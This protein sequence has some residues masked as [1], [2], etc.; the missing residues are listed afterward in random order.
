[1]RRRNLFLTGTA[2]AL[3]LFG[4]S[5]QE[6]PTVPAATAPTAAP[7]Q[8][9]APMAEVEKRASTAQAEAQKAA[10][11][12]QAKVESV[13]TPLVKTPEN[14][15]RAVPEAS[16]QPQLQKVL[17]QVKGLLSEKKYPE[18]LAAF[19]QLSNVN[20]TSE[21]QKLVQDLKAQVQTA[22]ASEKANE[23]LKSAGEL[24]KK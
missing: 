5:K 11:E 20:L 3:L 14:T 15:V 23:G 2:L 6:E 17:D 12:A 9:P 22:M 7:A 4:C 24:F 1:M 10:A 16:G 21:Q 18:A 13:P 8:A 19:S